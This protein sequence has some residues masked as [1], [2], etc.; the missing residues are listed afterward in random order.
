[1][2]ETLSA[3][4]LKLDTATHSLENISKRRNLIVDFHCQT[5]S[6][7]IAKT[8][9]NNQRILLRWILQQVPLIESEPIP[10]LSSGKVST[11]TPKQR[12]ERRKDGSN[13]TAKRR[14]VGIGATTTHSNIPASTN[15]GPSAR[16]TQSFHANSD[17]LLTQP[18]PW[19][20]A[21]KLTSDREKS[22]TMMKNWSQVYDEKIYNPL[23]RRSSRLRRPPERFQ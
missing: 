2:K 9:T 16:Q 13:S 21:S 17:I 3:A 18:L 1:M 22:G 12:S 15:H 7:N 20:R 23:P 10:K 11:Q 14:K 8:Y 6:Y 19:T 5:K 4:K